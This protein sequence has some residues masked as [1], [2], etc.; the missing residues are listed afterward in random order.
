M[1]IGIE[2]NADVAVSEHL[3]ERFDIYAGLH[4]ASCK[5]MAQRVVI[6]CG[7]TAIVKDLVIAVLKCTGL[8]EFTRSRQ[9]KAFAGQIF[10]FEQY[11][12]QRR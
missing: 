8:D 9:E 4:A 1:Y 5:S 2:R 6:H 3:T 11:R 10:Q 7:D 12:Q